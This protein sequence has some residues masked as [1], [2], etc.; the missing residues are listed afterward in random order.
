MLTPSA[1]LVKALLINGARQ[2]AGQFDA[3]GVE[4]VPNIAAGFGRVDM[5]ATVGPLL[6]HQSLVL[7]D[8][9]R[10]LVDEELAITQIVITPPGTTLKATL[11]WTDP[12]GAKLQNDLD[13]I[14]KTADGKERHGNM[15]PDSAD[16]DRNN[17]VEQVMWTHIPEG[18]V[19]VIVKAERL[20]TPSQTYA[21]VIRT[22]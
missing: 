10:A 14:V 3:P 11:V 17:N 15:K 1:A 6:E 22:T 13:L 18:A 8:E 19:E 20:S 7:Q 16:F 12:P 4:G 21:L 9:G 5:L 2:I